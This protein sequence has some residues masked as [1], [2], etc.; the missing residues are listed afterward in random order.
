MTNRLLDYKGAEA[1]VFTRDDAR[2]Y[3]RP[4]RRDPSVTTVIGRVFPH[5]FTGVPAQTLEHARAR[6]QEVHA[7]LALIYGASVNRTLDWESMDPEVRPRVTL[8]HDWLQRHHWEARYVERAFYSDMYGIGGTPDQVGHFDVGPD[9]QTVVLDFKPRDS[10]TADLQLA[11]YAICVA[12]SLGLKDVPRRVS[13]NCSGKEVLP[14]EYQ[15]HFRDKGEFL[16]TLAAYRC[17]VRKG[18]WK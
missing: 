15:H 18:W 4:G 1:S 3:V 16:G 5:L 14:I 10:E 7:S 12:E 13:L 6:G 17:G 2:Y 8:I 11:G 9:Y